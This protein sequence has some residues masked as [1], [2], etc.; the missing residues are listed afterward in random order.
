MLKAA[1]NREQYQWFTCLRMLVE[2]IVPLTTLDYLPGIRG[3]I[4]LEGLRVFGI[5][6]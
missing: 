5:L 3:G 1:P 6:S 4:I 2:L